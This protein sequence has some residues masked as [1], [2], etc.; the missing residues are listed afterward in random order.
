MR[1]YNYEILNEIQKRW[2]PRAFSEES[3]SNEDLEAIMEAARYAPSCFN[4]QPWLY[5]VA[6]DEPSLNVMRELL[7]EKNWLWAKKA[8]VLIMVLCKNKFEHNDKDNAYC[9]FDT[10]TSW[11]YL[12]LEATKRGYQTHA[13]A[14]FRKKTAREVLNIPEVYTPLAMIALGRPGLIEDLPEAFREK[15]SPNT[16]KPLNEVM[17]KIDYFGGLNEEN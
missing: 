15:E 16:R 10:G 5:L 11:G 8:P 7:M 12:S 3:V 6:D 14:G 4:E 17:V 2:S 1:I 13:M 9:S